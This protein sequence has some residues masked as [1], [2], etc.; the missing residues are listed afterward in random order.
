MEKFKAWYEKNYKGIYSHAVMLDADVMDK[1][2]QHL[3]KARLKPED[4][5]AVGMLNRVAEKG[6]ALR[7][8]MSVFQFHQ[9]YND[10][11]SPYTTSTPYED[12][13]FHANSAGKKKYTPLEKSIWGATPWG[14]M[15]SVPFGIP[16]NPK[17]NEVEDDTG[18]KPY[19]VRKDL[20]EIKEKMMMRHAELNDDI[21]EG[22]AK[23]DLDIMQVADAIRSDVADDIARLDV[24][25]DKQIGLIE[26]LDQ[27]ISNIK[28]RL[29]K[30]EKSAS[31][32][33]IQS[34]EKLK[35]GEQGV[36]LNVLTGKGNDECA[37]NVYL[38][39]GI[40][41]SGVSNYLRFLAN[42]FHGQKILTFSEWE[43]L[44]F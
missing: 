12:G 27:E 41:A 42:G 7:D 3:N 14:G 20:L 5:A 44:P 6:K 2:A 21:Q 11:P 19:D 22:L 40:G 16:S 35:S 30:M 32:T 36:W 8:E 10:A 17:P 23:V 13:E 1:W 34:P 4:Y 31:S 39:H 38:P 9:P 43:Q 24:R 37:C 15:E 25:L 26:D 18:C 33:H 29:D 28:E